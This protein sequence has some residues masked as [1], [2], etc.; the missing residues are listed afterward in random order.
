MRPPTDRRRRP[1]HQLLL[2]LCRA[3]TGCSRRPNTICRA[4]P[5]PLPTPPLLRIRSRS[6]ATILADFPPPWTSGLSRFANRNVGNNLARGQ[7]RL[8]RRGSACCRNE[9]LRRAA[10]ATIFT[11]VGVDRSGSPTRRTD[12]NLISYC[13]SLYRLGI[14]RPFAAFGGAPALD[15]ASQPNVRDRKVSPLSSSV[16]GRNGSAKHVA[17]LSRAI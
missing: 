7:R 2:T 11:Q 10:D 16:A 6:R 8:S 5:R 4:Q 13:S 12:R 3:G 17:P 1:S 9:R 14:E 15:V